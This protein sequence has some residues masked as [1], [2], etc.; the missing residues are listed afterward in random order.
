MYAGDRGGRSV[1]RLHPTRARGR[2]SERS[3]IRCRRGVALE[4]RSG[5]TQSCRRPYMMLA[6]DSRNDIRV[7]PYLKIISAWEENIS[8]DLTELF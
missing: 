2:G 1:R 7:N 4:S 5:T 6:Y 3:R 8:I